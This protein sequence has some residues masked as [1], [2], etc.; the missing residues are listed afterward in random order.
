MSNSAV[1]THSSL[2]VTFPLATTCRLGQ[3]D[4]SRPVWRRSLYR[5]HHCTGHSDTYTAGQAHP[6][7][8]NIPLNPSTP[9]SKQVSK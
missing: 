6:S 4:L 3:I 7:A 1:L 8:A 9:F 2:P 5:I